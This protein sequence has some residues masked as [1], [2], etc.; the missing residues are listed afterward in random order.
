ML[1]DKLKTLRTSQRISQRELAERIGVNKS[2]ISF[3]EN[4]ERF[5]SYDVLVRIAAIF[6]VTT[7]YL[8]DVERG[9][10]IDVTGL[11]DDDIAAV[12]GIV[13]ALKRKPK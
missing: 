1:C 5:P 8:L 6:H 12:R 7:D 3:Y 10:S 11:S 4:G 2:I 9:Q 13:D